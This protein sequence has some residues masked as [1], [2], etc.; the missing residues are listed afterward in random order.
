MMTGV[1]STLSERTGP[2]TTSAPFLISAEEARS[3]RYLNVSERGFRDLLKRG[4]PYVKVGKRK[5]FPPHEF[6]DWLSEQARQ[7]SKS[8]DGKGRRTGTSRGAST[9]VAFDKALELTTRT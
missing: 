9:V 4:L 3:P 6:K 2:A 8:T 7:C 1:D 5:M